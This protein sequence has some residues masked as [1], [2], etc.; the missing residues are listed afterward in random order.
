MFNK[1]ETLDSKLY[2]LGSGGTILKLE[3]VLLLLII[4]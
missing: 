1:G 4:F 3:C 2:S